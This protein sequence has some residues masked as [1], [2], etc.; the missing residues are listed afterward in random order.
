MAPPQ[1]LPGPS[2][3]MLAAAEGPVAAP[4]RGPQLAGPLP[5]PDTAAPPP[6]SPAT[7]AGAQMRAE[8]AAP[9]EAPPPQPAPGK[10]PQQQALDEANYWTMQEARVPRGLPGAVSAFRARQ[11]D[12]LSRAKPNQEQSD[13]MEENWRRAQAKEPLL[14]SPSE[15]KLYKE[16]QLPDYKQAAEYADKYREKSRAAVDTINSV[17]AFKTLLKHPGMES[18]SGL[19]AFNYVKGVARNLKDAAVSAGVIASDD[20]IARTID[21]ATESVP[22]REAANALSKQ[23]TIT[24]IGGL[25][26]GKSDSDRLITALTVPGLETS[27]VGAEITASYLEAKA[28][29]AAAIGEL[30]DKYHEEK[31]HNMKPYALENKVRAYQ[32]SHGILVNSDGT[33]TELGRK[34]SM[35]EGRFRSGAERPPEAPKTRRAIRGPDGKLYKLGPGGTPIPEDSEGL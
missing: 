9:P 4:P 1:A 28:K 23:M 11:Q 33:P 31:G 16:T 10:S 25:G 2:E 24:S 5:Q 26:A 7:V 20:P 13:F 19:D 35:V 3:Q 34:L 12:A 29:N 15:F 27:K 21:S 17:N 6:I 18:G 22:L 30:V 32:N 8:P 14:Q